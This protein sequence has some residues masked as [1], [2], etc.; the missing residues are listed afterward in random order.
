MRRGLRILKMIMFRALKVTYLSS[1]ILFLAG[2]GIDMSLF[3]ENNNK[4]LEKALA[5]DFEINKILVRFQE[6][7]KTGQKPFAST[8][9]NPLMKRLKYDPRYLFFLFTLLSLEVL[10]S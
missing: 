7:R 3:N 6:M 2:I 1:F 4:S 10:Q 5:G 9:L 8:F